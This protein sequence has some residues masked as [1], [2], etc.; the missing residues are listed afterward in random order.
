[1]RGR[2]RLRPWS[3]LT[4][5]PP[6]LRVGKIGKRDPRWLPYQARHDELHETSVMCPDF[7]KAMQRDFPTCFLFH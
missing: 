2:Q 5:A 1:M 6:E 4:S 7:L 3:N